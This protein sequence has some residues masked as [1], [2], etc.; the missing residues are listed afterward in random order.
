M[1][2]EC[3]VLIQINTE[4][5]TWINACFKVFISSHWR[6]KSMKSALKYPTIELACEN[7]EKQLISKKW[8]LNLHSHKKYHKKLLPI[9][10]MC[11]VPFKRLSDSSALPHKGTTECSRG[12]TWWISQGMQQ[13]STGNFHTFSLQV[14]S[15][16]S[17]AFVQLTDGIVSVERCRFFPTKASH[18][19]KKKYFVQSQHKGWRP[20]CEIQRSAHWKH[21][22][23]ENQREHRFS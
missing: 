3:S 11:L 8:D 13:F 5:W 20:P 23:G 7:I 10:Y 6:P 22:R 16:H 4:K 21:S 2:V 9:F 15:I 19:Q 1:N 18:L 17:A 14:N 12:E